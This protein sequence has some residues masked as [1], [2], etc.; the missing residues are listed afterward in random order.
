MSAVQKTLRPHRI[1]HYSTIHPRNVNKTVMKRQNIQ[2]N[3]IEMTQSWGAKER[4]KLSCHYNN[5]KMSK[6][7][8]DNTKLQTSLLTSSWTTR[9]QHSKK[10]IPKQKQ[11]GLYWKSGE[12]LMGQ[13]RGPSKK[14]NSKNEWKEQSTNAMDN[15]KAK[16]KWNSGG[17]DSNSSFQSYLIIQAKKVKSSV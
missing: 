7:T 15:T 1:R 3:N 13:K 12:L 11:T 6:S 2:T 17:W 8:L 16:W 5:M 14:N 9:I 4:G 10:L